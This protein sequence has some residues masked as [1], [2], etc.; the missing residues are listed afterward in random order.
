M[1][2]RKKDIKNQKHI[3]EF[4]VLFYD[5]VQKDRLLRLY[6]K[7]FNDQL[8]EDHIT[9][10]TSFWSN[11]VFQTEN[12]QGNPMSTHYKIHQIK[13]ITPN[14]FKRWLNLFEQAVTQKFEGENVQIVLEKARSIAVILQRN[15]KS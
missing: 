6:F 1:A 13:K 5:L 8:W 9:V 12:Y 14:A 10:M 3:Q 4:I 7:S 2:T 15:I 11:V